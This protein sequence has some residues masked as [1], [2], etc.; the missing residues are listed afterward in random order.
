MTIVIVTI[1]NRRILTFHPAAVVANDDVAFSVLRQSKLS[2][3][4]NPVKS[5]QKEIAP[6]VFRVR[7]GG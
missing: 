2:L 3:G 6:G 4:R 1:I 5:H 7:A